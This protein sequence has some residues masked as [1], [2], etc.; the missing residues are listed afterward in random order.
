MARLQQRPCTAVLVGARRQD[1]VVL[2][3]EPSLFG[4]G[5][6][7]SSEKG[8]RVG[9]ELVRGGQFCRE[10]TVAKHLRLKEPSA[11]TVPAQVGSG[12]EGPAP[13]AAEE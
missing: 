10:L 2:D 6:S 8:S 4:S 7:G 3:V 1:A 9:A 12:D 13:G 11:G 5:E